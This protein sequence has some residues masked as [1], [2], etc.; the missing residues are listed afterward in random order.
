AERS[1]GGERQIVVLDQSGDTALFD[2]IKEHVETLRSQSKAEGDEGFGRPTRFVLTRQIVPPDQNPNDLIKRQFNE[3]GGKASEKS[4][5][6]LVPRV[7]E[8]DPPAYHAKNLSDFS[9]RALEDAVSAAIW[10]RRLIR[11]GVDPTKISGYMN[12]VDLK[13]FKIGATGES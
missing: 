6:I 10:E 2:A 1:S 3:E 9:I 5:L 13:K 12:P 4:F 11:A 8:N 7:L